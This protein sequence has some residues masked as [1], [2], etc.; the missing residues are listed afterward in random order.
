[1]IRKRKRLV[2]RA[3]YEGQLSDSEITEK[4]RLAPKTLQKWIQ[5]PQFQQYL[6][7]L[8][9]EAERQVRF[10][11]SRWGP[12]AAMKL[13]ELAGSDKENVARKAAV[14]MI[15]R[16]LNQNKIKNKNEPTE[17][18]PHEEMTEELAKKILQSL[19]ENV[20]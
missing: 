17:D 4:F 8:C 18:Q 14:D 9:D 20:T 13:V 10:I 3:V 16:C 11:V 5:E 15:D 6:E 1:M 19:A 7:Q 12:L 2:A